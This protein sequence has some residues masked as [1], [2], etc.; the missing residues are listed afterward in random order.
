[1]RKFI[2]IFVIA[3]S[4]L[5]VKAQV[6]T[7]VDTTICAGKTYIV[8]EPGTTNQ[9][10]TVNS[11][12]THA[13]YPYGT[14]GS[15]DTL[16]LTL[17]FYPTYTNTA[18]VTI[19]ASDL[20]YT[21]GSEVF[22]VGTVS[23]TY[24][25]HFQ[26]IHGCDSL[27]NLTLTVL[28]D[29]TVT[30]LKNDNRANAY[31]NG[32]TA[33]TN[34]AFMELSQE[35]LINFNSTNKSI[36]DIRQIQF[37]IDS[38]A[39]LSVSGC[40][41]IIMQGQTFATATVRQTQ[42]VMGVV[43]YWNTVNLTNAYTVDAS[44][45]LYIGYE[46]TTS[47]GAYPFT[48]ASGTETKQ[49]WFKSGSNSVNIITD[50]GYSYVFLIKAK[51][52]FTEAPDDKMA[53]Y[54]ITLEKNKI[55]GESVTIKGTV[56]NLGKNTV[57]SFKVQYTVDGAPSTKET[58]N[59]N[60]APNATYNFTHS[61]TYTL[62]TAKVYSIAVT[63]SDVNGKSDGIVG[64]ATY[65][66]EVRVYAANTARTVLHEVFTSATCPPCKPGNEKLKDVL[67]IKNPNNWA[68]VKYQYDFPG[69]GDPY[70]TSECKTR[71][72]FYGGIGSVP[73]LV[74]DGQFFKNPNSY[75]SSD[76]NQLAKVPAAATMTGTSTITDKT[77]SLNVTIN[78]VINMNNPNLRFFA[79]IVEKKT[80][81]N[82][83]QSPNQSNG[84]T[85]FHYVMKKFMTSVNGDNIGSL[86][87][88]TP[89]TRSLSYT[90][91]GNYRLPAN[92]KNNPINHASE[93]SVENF[94][95]LMVVYWLQDIVTKEVFQAH[96]PGAVPVGVTDIAPKS[97]NAILY[98]NPVNDNLYISTDAEIS[99]IEIF[100][101]QGQCLKI[102]QTTD[103]SIST[104]N[105]ANGMYML[106]ITSD[107]GVSVH[108]FV[109]Q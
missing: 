15:E 66:S 34:A 21:Y 101:I 41:V 35:D 83:N 106:R 78:P 32:N 53:F 47:A 37:H 25:V 52:T 91:N 99:K 45:K 79:A 88:N 67:D 18:A 33:S 39:F 61:E 81:E 40:K 56:K 103:K 94:T 42:A 30:W 29:I 2:V 86:V 54:P 24:P 49:A 19:L 69:N 72:T 10:G 57:T 50:Q 60:I 70:Y 12:C 80:V 59:V 13:K 93:H 8:Y 92:A 77:V 46:V 102:E 97:F 6:T 36:V 9:L 1:M 107:K 71:G 55:K 73:T 100:N 26:T 27:I 109:K 84:E 28:S 85:E 87:A 51:A 74:G 20:P 38:A 22:P 4:A 63:V 3:F 48:L 108:K 16:D 62:N 96:Y 43:R 89:V 90:F 14:V 17:N 76:F 64:D 58:F 98:P 65:T 75:T 23:G 31:G 11:Q 104:S 44:Q 5:S 95:N 7:Y 68:C 82:R 105:L